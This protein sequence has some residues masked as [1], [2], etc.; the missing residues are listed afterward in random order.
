MKTQKISEMTNI[1]TGI[2]GLDK[3]F[4]DKGL[5]LKSKE[6]TALSITIIG[7][8]GT[9]KALFGMQLLLGIYRSVY[10]NKEKI[11]EN[12]EEITAPFYYSKKDNDNVEDMY[13]DYT[14]SRYI[15]LLVES[16]IKGDLDKNHELNSEFASLFFDLL[17]DYLDSN[18][19]K[20]K[21]DKYISIGIVKYNNQNKTLEM[22]QTDA[23][24]Q[25]IVAKRRT[26]LFKSGKI[27]NPILKEIFPIEIIKYDPDEKIYKENQINSESEKKKVIP[28]SIIYNYKDKKP[29]N[30]TLVTIRV[31]EKEEKECE[32]NIDESDIIIELRSGE[33]QEE[34]YYVN[35]IIIRKSALQPAA[36]GWHRYK[37]RDFGIEIYPSIHLLLHEYDHMPNSIL[38]SSNSILHNEND[39][40]YQKDYGLS[41]KLFSL[42]KETNIFSS[43][44]VGVSASKIL[45]ELFIKPESYD[46]LGK[47]TALIGTA[48]T[49][50]RLLALGAVFSGSLRNEHTLYI[51]FNKDTQSM[52][53]KLLCPAVVYN[54]KSNLYKCKLSHSF[55]EDCTEKCKIK[56][57]LSCYDNIH[58]KNIRMGY[59]SSDEFFYYLIKQIELLKNKREIKRI[60]LDDIHV[61]DYSFPLL[62]KDDLFL[63]TFIAIC[64][65]YKIDLIVLCDKFATKT[66]E[67]RTIADNVVCTERNKDNVVINI[68][69][70]CGYSEP[71]HIFGYSIR[72]IKE[73]FY[74]DMEKNQ[75]N[76]H[77]ELNNNCIDEVLPSNTED[78]WVMNDTNKIVNHFSKIK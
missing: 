7:N 9:S 49:Y 30:N 77:I 31:I 12:N 19:V 3:L 75:S 61:V 6:T 13:L 73:L 55:C 47:C 57:C 78:Y 38:E 34:N 5:K 18:I 53:K 22:Q 45:N 60:V 16:Q 20:T 36:L 24:P 37:K 68:E 32:Y 70:F 62:K 58:F 54:K 56:R 76:P 48:N 28:C 41:S 69:R 67:L 39:F 52:I 63:T 11:L 71:S 44:N 33:D 50:K 8:S 66:Q 25:I 10:K 23:G 1:L 43:S 27:T 42:K 74:C 46:S 65:Q 40:L 51:L 2:D 4:Y 21:M 17:D 29:I 64:K 26:G 72:N 14:I 15:R 59:I 35:Q